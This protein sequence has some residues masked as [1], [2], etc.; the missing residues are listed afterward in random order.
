LQV[1]WQVMLLD[2]HLHQDGDSP[3]F[4]TALK[5]EVLFE[6]I[7]SFSDWR[8]QPMQKGE[9]GYFRS[10]VDFQTSVVR[11]KSSQRVIDSYDWQYDDRELP[12]NQDL[13]SY[14]MHVSDFCGEGSD[15]KPQS[16]FQQAI[17]KLDYLQELGINAIELLPITEYAGDYGWEYYK[18]L[19]QFCQQTPALRSD[20]IAFF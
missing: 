2:L 20:N 13:I 14:E 19:I 18:R 15:Q 10:Q 11:I 9:D 7:E 3:V 12:A 4:E 17:D 16:K 6:L 5:N 8:V 1:D